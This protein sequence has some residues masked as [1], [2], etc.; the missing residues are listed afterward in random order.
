M[1]TQS[2]ALTLQQNAKEQSL[3]IGH[4]PLSESEKETYDMQRAELES[5]TA[6]MKQELPPLFDPV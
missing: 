6:E 4:H 5:Y 3:H 2:T 1:H